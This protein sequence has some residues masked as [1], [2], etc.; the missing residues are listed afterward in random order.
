MDRNAIPV[1]TNKKSVPVDTTVLIL[2]FYALELLPPKM[3][4]PK[5]LAK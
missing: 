2:F 4:S 3:D 1:D 5:K